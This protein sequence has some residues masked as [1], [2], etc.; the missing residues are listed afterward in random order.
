MAP[1]WNVT[2]NLIEEATLAENQ[3]EGR[4]P[5][6]TNP[7]SQRHAMDWLPIVGA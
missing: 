6:G 3:R 5:V 1:R 2:V 7:T 4:L